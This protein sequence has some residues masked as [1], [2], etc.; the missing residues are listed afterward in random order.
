MLGLAE[1]RRIA[2]HAAGLPSGARP[3]KPHGYSPPYR[4]TTIPL[5]SYCRICLGSKRIRSKAGAAA[6]SWRRPCK[7]TQSSVD[8]HHC[9]E[10]TVPLIC[11]SDTLIRVP[12]RP[13]PPACSVLHTH[14][15]PRAPPSRPVSHR[16]PWLDTISPDWHSP[17]LGRRMGPEEDPRPRVGGHARGSVASMSAQHG[18]RGSHVDDLVGTRSNVSVPHQAVLQHRRGMLTNSRRLHSCTP[19]RISGSQTGS[20]VATS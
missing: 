20:V 5:S 2:S 17:C 9:Q 7:R 12:C 4:H 18:N 6:R 13:T 1:G 14:S 10:R 15:L 8:D 19:H 11:V 3:W 16:P